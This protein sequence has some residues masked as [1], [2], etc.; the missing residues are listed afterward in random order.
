MKVINVLTPES[1][2]KRLDA[3]EANSQKDCVNLTLNDGQHIRLKIPGPGA[4]L[5]AAI[6]NQKPYYKKYVMAAVDTGADCEKIIILAQAIWK[7]HNMRTP[8]K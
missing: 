5:T 1:L 7:S 8:V 4:P 3:I 2:L 6:Y